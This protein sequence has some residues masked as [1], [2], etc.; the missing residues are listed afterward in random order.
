MPSSLHNY[1]MGSGT[2]YEPEIIRSPLS[3][4]SP[5]AVHTVNQDGSTETRTVYATSTGEALS[6]AA[7]GLTVVPRGLK[8]SKC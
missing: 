8:V 2:S 3:G 1:L 5:H 6:M 4:L 7:A